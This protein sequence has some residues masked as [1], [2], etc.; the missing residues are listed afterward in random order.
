LDQPYLN[1]GSNV[2]VIAIASSR[3][4]K[5]FY[6][7]ELVAVGVDTQINTHAIEVNLAAISANLYIL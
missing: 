2:Y 6:A 1:N 3:H 7:K 4:F 5:I